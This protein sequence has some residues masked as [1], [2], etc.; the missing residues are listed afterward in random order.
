MTLSKKY[1]DIKINS[2]S[3]IDD[4]P[5]YNE[6][7]NINKTINLVDSNHTN[8]SLKNKFSYEKLKKLVHYHDQPLCTINFFAHAL[9]QEKI[10]DDG[11]KVSISGTGADEIFSGYYDHHLYFLYSIK[12]NSKYS[13]Y[14]NSWEK[15][16]KKIINPLLKD[17]DF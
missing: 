7:K 14:L 11:F 9:L 5:R 10:H 1:F 6:S 16:V 12:E 13:H 8:I 3:I 15:N 17:L 4:D 2:Y